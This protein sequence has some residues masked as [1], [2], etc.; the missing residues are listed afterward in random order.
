MNKNNFDFLRFLF[1]LLVVMG[2][3]YTLSGN[4]ESKEFISLITNKQLSLTSIGLNGF[5]VISGYLIF[6]SL[7]NSNTLKGYYWRRFLRLYPGLFVVLLITIFL[8]PFLYESEISFLKNKDVYTY[9]PNNLSLYR[10]Q[11]SI[12]GVLSKNTYHSAI[13][14]SLWT[15][16]YEFTLYLLLSLL[17]LF[18]NNIKIVQGVL[19]VLFMIMYIGYVFYFDYLSGINFIGLEGKH[20]LNLGNFFICGSLL[21]SLQIEKMNYKKIGL[22][23]VFFIFIIS[24][25][26]GV[27]NLSKHI[28]F[29]ILI[30][31]VALNRI[32]K[33]CKF[34]KIGDL[35]YGIY[36]Y[37]FPI[38]QIL[39]YFFKFNG[40]QLLFMSLVLSIFF[41]FFSWH[42]I[43][44]KAMS[45]KGVIS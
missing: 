10:I 17:I 16:C 32:N 23:L 25:Y 38:Q 44:K 11:Y 30:L 22:G 18:R 19:F 1:A 3:S 6:K 15:I 33:I 14:G 12:Q 20:F 40:K 29:S 37:S 9:L 31:V 4:G 35:S 45:Y 5:F 7:M 8:S 43:E 13:N 36:I 41:G 26:F 39:M 27:Y 34:G 2:H 21:S 28:L 42:L 24:I